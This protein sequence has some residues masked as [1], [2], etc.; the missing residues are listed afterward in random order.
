M[1]TIRDFMET[2]NYRITEASDYCWSCYGPDA[3]QFD[4]WNGDNDYGHSVGVV[5]DKKTQIVYQMEA[6]DYKNSRAYRWINPNYRKLYEVES[7]QKD[8]DMD[9]A[10]DGV[11]F[12]DIE[13]TGDM[14]EKSRAIVAGLNYDTRVEVPLEIDDDVILEI[15]LQAHKRDITIN[16]MVEILLQQVIDARK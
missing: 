5:F 1:I 14:L 4:S 7:Q 3:Y 12:T 15:A 9:E 10:Y 16:K 13:T 6:H 8:V 2:V 11:K